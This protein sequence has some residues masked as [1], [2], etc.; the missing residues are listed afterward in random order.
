MCTRSGRL[1]II[2]FGADEFTCGVS[3]DV[4]VQLSAVGTSI[5]D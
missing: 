5:V 1:P 2:F 3:I 4:R